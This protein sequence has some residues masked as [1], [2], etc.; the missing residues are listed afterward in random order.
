MFDTAPLQ[1][2]LS[3]L[4]F[5]PEKSITRKVFDNTV[6]KSVCLLSKTLDNWNALLQTLEGHSNS[7]TSVAFSP[8]GA[9]LASG[10]GDKTIKLWDAATGSLQRTLEG[11]SSSVT[12]IAFSPDGTQ[13]ETEKGFINLQGNK[14]NAASLHPLSVYR[15]FVKNEWIVQDNKRL[16]WLPFEYR[17]VCSDVQGDK[18]V[19]G[20]ASGQ[21]TLLKFDFSTLNQLP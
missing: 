7:V 1:V 17:A 12:S 8:D 16:L 10:S 11:H 13:L 4:I 3:G 18:I 21:I 6:L 19:L 20:H 9:Q 5:A 14:T 2:Y 15:I